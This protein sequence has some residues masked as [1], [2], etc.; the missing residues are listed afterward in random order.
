M[1]LLIMTINWCD[2]CYGKVASPKINLTS[3]E[4]SSK[5]STVQ[6]MHTACSPTSSFQTKPRPGYCE[7]SYLVSKCEKCSKKHKYM[8][9]ESATPAS[10]AFKQ[11]V[12][13]YTVDIYKINPV[14]VL[15]VISFI[16]MI[17]CMKVF[18][19]VCVCVC[20]CFLFFWGGGGEEGYVDRPQLAFDCS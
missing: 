10:A 2:S 6:L 9:E 1:M 17:P 13:K 20:V 3:F 14:F 11:S 12:L 5:N 16:L 15:A 19:C 7:E 4:L 8:Y 18:C